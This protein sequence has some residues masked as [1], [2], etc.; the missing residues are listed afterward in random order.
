MLWPLRF[1]SF[2][3]RVRGGSTFPRGRGCIAPATILS[4]IVAAPAPTVVLS[5]IITPAVIVLGACLVII[6]G[7][8]A[9]KLLAVGAHIIVIV[10]RRRRCG[11]SRLAPGGGRGA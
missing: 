6:H 9:T 8:I 1:G 2:R 7:A 10:V 5:S 3:P 11:R 4:G